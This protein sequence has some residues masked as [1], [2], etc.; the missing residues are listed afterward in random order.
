MIDRKILIGCV[1]VVLFGG[2]LVSQIRK[3]SAPVPPRPGQPT[4]SQEPLMVSGTRLLVEIADDDLERRQG[5]SDRSVLTP[6]TGMLFRFSQPQ[7]RAF[8]MKDMRFPLDI[9][10]IRDGAVQE[11]FADVQPRTVSGT[12]TVVAP[13]APADTVLEVPAGE[14]ARQDWRIGDRVFRPDGS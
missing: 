2:I 13:A 6:G 5:L 11:I 14:S 1:V 7:I 12:I 4:L 10:Y 9:L 3:I 8:W